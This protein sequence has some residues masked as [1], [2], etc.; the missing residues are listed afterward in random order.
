[1]MK[2]NYSKIGVTR[3]LLIAE[4]VFI[5]IILGAALIG[6]GSDLETIVIYLISGIAWCGLTFA[7]ISYN[8]KV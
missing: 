6:K 1:M 4:F 5:I 8:G 3:V 2:H 7:I